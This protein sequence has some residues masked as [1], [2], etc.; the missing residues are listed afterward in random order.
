MQESRIVRNKS[1]EN[2]N[3][4]RSGRKSRSF[5]TFSQNLQKTAKNAENGLKNQIFAKN[6]HNNTTTQHLHDM[7]TQQIS[8]NFHIVLIINILLNIF[9][10]LYPVVS[11]CVL[12]FSCCILLCFG[13]K[14]CV[15][16]VVNNPVNRCEN[17][18]FWGK[19]QQK[20]DNTQQTQQD[21]KN[22]KYWEIGF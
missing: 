3:I 18:T 16:T 11:C 9:L 20:N 22:T 4:K 15:L 19:T 21:N 17:T 2:S 1:K 5:L 8:S 7:F 13:A 12:L 10:I 14:C 6:A